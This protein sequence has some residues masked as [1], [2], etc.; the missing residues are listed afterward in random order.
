MGRC[1]LSIDRKKE[2][3]PRELTHRQSLSARS[4]RP[5]LPRFA[6]VRQLYWQCGTIVPVL[7]DEETGT[8][9]FTKV[10]FALS[11]LISPC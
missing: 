5:L 9:L 3:S 2:L 6:V 10:V 4:S 7:L 1:T 8:P 11:S